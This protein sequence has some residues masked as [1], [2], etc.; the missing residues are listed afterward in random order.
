MTEMDR[1]KFI[2]RC[3]AVGIAVG[4]SARQE[5]G[6]ASSQ[7][8][9][10]SSAG[11]IAEK[12]TPVGGDVGQNGELPKQRKSIERIGCGTVSFRKLSLEEAMLRIARAGYEY[13]E[14]Q[15]TAPFC[16]HVNP[17]NDD[18]VK[19]KDRVKELGFKGA[20]ALWAPNGAI[21]SDSNSVSG[22][23]QAIQ[24]ASEAG[25]PVVNAGDGRKPDDLSH[26]DALRLL[27]DRLSA[28]LSVAE[29][30]KVRLAIEPHGTYSLTSDGMN[31]IMALSRS[32]W[33]G[34]NY[35]AAN[36][37]LALYRIRNVTGKSAWLPYGQMQDEV[38]TLRSIADR[39]VHFHV[40]DI[41]GSDCVAL[42]AGDVNNKGCIEVLLDRGFE[43]VM[44]VETEGDFGSE[45]AQ[46]LIEISR[47]YLLKVSE[48]SEGYNKLRG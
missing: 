22:I 41:R 44:S 16:P 38:E 36:I 24:W 3:A 47:K 15:A 35:D 8:A 28:I 17:W 2:Q 31:R 48:Q 5:M 29:R 13:V 46:N 25:I 23:S 26:E 7:P 42:G 14:P 37:R 40:K 4:V 9:G 12:A 43:G 18:P 10:G 27:G 1:R 32:R 33:F 34:I 6:A 11:R 30:C 39:V 45:Q 19:F 21:L 20:S